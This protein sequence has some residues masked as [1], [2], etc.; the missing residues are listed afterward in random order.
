[1]RKKKTGKKIKKRAMS[2]VEIL[3]AIFISSMLLTVVI[4][5]FYFSNKASVSSFEKAEAQQ[6]FNTA[7]EY[8]TRDLH[9]TGSSVSISTCG[10][11]KEDAV[12]RVRNTNMTLYGDID[13]DPNNI[14]K[15]EYFLTNND[16]CLI[17][18]VYAQQG[19]GPVSTWVN[20]NEKVLIGNR[21]SDKKSSKIQI[22]KS[23][24]QFTYYDFRGNKLGIPPGSYN[25]YNEEEVLT[26]SNYEKIIQPAFAIEG[27]PSATPVLPTPVPATPTL[28]SGE[29]T[30]TAAPGKTA[31]AAVQQ[32]SA[33]NTATA[34]PGKTATAAV[35]TATAG[36]AKT[37]TKAAQQTAAP[38]Q[39]ATA[40]VK[41][42]TAAP[43][44]TATKAAQQ[45]A[46]PGQT[47]T[48][49]VK[50]ATAAP[51]KTATAAVKTATAG[52][53]QTATK[54]AEETAAPGKTATA[55]AIQTATAA[56]PTPT[57]APIQPSP[58][59]PTNVERFVRSVAVTIQIDNIKGAQVMRQSSTNI[60]IKNLF[61]EGENQ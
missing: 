56:S 38:G 10:I 61:L 17:R 52:P 41:T 22:G 40:A 26:A 23:G 48:A 37:A 35:K 14:E 60:T 7:I 11:P 19:T 36:P 46:A 28:T 1:M 57:K 9:S 27:L 43:A 24:I 49:A 42:A 59:S 31:T 12:G 58:T 32:T 29:L 30:A 4:G 55:G 13:D 25:P 18:R 44:K 21:N 45:T 16:T 15:I 47:A 54:A 2:L 51:G 33:V 20:P 3:V 5:L 8:I 39:T 34:A 6:S 50:T 53:A